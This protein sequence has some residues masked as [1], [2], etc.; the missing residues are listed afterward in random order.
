MEKEELR[1]KIFNL[2]NSYAYRYSENPFKLASGK[3]SHHYFNCKD[4]L[5]YPDRLNPVSDYIIKYLI[6]EF[7]DGVP[8]SIGGLTL[9]ADPLSYSLSQEY[10][11]NSKIVYPLVVRKEAK[12]HGTQK[13]IEGAIDKVASCLVVDDVITTG[14]STLKAIQALRE[15][16][17][18][19]KYGICLIDREEGGTE[20]LLTEGVKIFSIFHKSD[21]FTESSR[22]D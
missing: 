16:G 6:P 3:M 8:E 21:F 7:M 22:N 17:K 12:A 4:I 18:E 10:F 9:G 20:T 15:A 14:G 5:M 1:K 2:F 13:K 11:K 19:V